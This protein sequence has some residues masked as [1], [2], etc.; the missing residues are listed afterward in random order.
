MS[1]GT[2]NTRT[3]LRLRDEHAENRPVLEGRLSGAVDRALEE[4]TNVCGV[5]NLK[6]PTHDHLAEVELVLWNALR[7][8]N[9]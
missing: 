6:M 7:E 1:L 3:I 2:L 9:T 5:Y 8:A 4:L